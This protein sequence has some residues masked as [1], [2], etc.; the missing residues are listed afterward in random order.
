MTTTPITLSNLKPTFGSRR[1]PLRLGM[2]E[3][4]GTGQTAT[5]GQKG[6]RSRSGDGKL[7]GFEGGQTPLLRRIPKRG[8][9]N[10]AFK[11]VYQTISLESLERV[12]KNK[13]DIA[14]EDLRIHGLVK[15]RKLVK[16]LGDGE[17]K[18]A[19]KVT[20][21]AFSQSA[22]AKIEKAGGKAEVVKA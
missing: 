18:R 21:H 3:G 19:L 22:K 13:T 10:G 1:R 8:F 11:V 15:G 14:I 7:V 17:L 20:A 6:Q 16:I 4:S 2:G 12:F 5:R 9:T